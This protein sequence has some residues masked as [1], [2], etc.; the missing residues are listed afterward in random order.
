MKYDLNV[1]GVFVPSLLVALAVTYGL[2]S[3]S[4]R[5]LRRAG[6]YRFVWHS[7]L[8]DVAVFICLL[9]GVVYISSELFP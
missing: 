1:Y 5:L 4:S 6:L 9:A 8:F 7:A 3:L 2:A